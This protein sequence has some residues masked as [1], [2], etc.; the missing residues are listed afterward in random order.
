MNLIFDQ[1]DEGNPILR[2]ATHLWI[3]KTGFNAHQD[4]KVLFIF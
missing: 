1:P 3:A 2:F 4:M